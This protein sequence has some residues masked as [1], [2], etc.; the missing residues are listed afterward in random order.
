[1]KSVGTETSGPSAVIQIPMEVLFYIDR[2][3][4]VFVQ[5]VPMKFLE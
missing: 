3:V 2:S 5:G 1:V 4:Q